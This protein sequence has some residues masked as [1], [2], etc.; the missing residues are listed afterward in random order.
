MRYQRLFEIN[1]FHEY[2]QDKVC[3]DLIIEPTIEC[4]KILNGHRLI[5][6]NKSNGI[7]VIAAVDQ[8]SSNK[9]FIKL[10]DNLKFTFILSIRNSSFLDF[11]DFNFEQE[12]INTKDALKD[13][14]DVL[15]GIFHNRIT[16]ILSI[17]N[18]SFLDF[19][20]EQEKINTK[21]A[22]KD[23][24]DA[25]KGIFHNCKT[26]DSV[27]KDVKA[28]L[29]GFLVLENRNG[30][31]LKELELDKIDLDKSD[32][33]LSSIPLATKQKIFGAIVIDNQLIDLNKKPSYS[34]TFK[35]KKQKWQYYLITQKTKNADEYEFSIVDNEENITFEK[36]EEID[37]KK[38]IPYLIH[39][40]F[41]TSSQYRFVSVETVPCCDSGYKYIQ[42]LKKENSKKRQTRNIDLPSS[43]SDSKKEEKRDIVWIE[44]LPNPPNHSGI[45]I[46]NTLKYF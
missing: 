4:R 21:D 41:P 5:L 16:F 20:F 30:S 19:N 25:L 22:L 34:Y 11:T 23:V 12:K 6:K 40:Q 9:P 3:N 33:I 13:V 2:Y 14:R 39:Q 35:S 44:H 36:I 17:R 28:I 29:I 37:K 18:L 43:S 26:K 7:E 8:N 32:T 10:A 42:L 46:I 24:R 45:Q 27:L 1:I 31:K 38:G 15:K